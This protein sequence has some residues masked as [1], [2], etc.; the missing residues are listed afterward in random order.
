M[1]LKRSK[2]QS[3]DPSVFV[4]EKGIPIPTATRGVTNPMTEFAIAM[5]PGDSF[6][7]RGVKGQLVSQRM[8]V[9]RK[10]FPKRDYVIRTV[11]GGTRIWRGKDKKQPHD[12]H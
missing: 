3:K 11:E 5:K 9:A 1:K 12:A 7:V 8:Q 6:L 4:M 10:K 2:N